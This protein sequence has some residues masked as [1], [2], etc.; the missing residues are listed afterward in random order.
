M[1]EMLFLLVCILDYSRVV[2][3]LF[4]IQRSRPMILFSCCNYQPLLGLALLLDQIGSQTRLVKLFSHTHLFTST[5][6]SS[7][8]KGRK[9]EVSR[10]RQNSLTMPWRQT[11]IRI[12]SSTRSQKSWIDPGLR[13]YARSVR[14]LENSQRHNSVPLGQRA[15]GIEEAGHMLSCVTSTT[16][17]FQNL[18]SLYSDGNCFPATLLGYTLEEQMLQRAFPLLA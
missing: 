17:D 6:P 10:Q 2:R 12:F 16:I 14:D 13:L 15:H 1:Q 8:R 18:N 3:S 4:H 5:P 9:I 7:W 11:F